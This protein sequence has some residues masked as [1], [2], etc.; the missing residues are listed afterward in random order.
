FQKRSATQVAK[1]KEKEGEEP[2][3]IDP[4]P[5]NIDSLVQFQIQSIDARFCDDLAKFWKDVTKS[6][7]EG[8][9][10]IRGPKDPAS[11][12]GGVKAPEGKAWVVEVSGFTYH[13]GKEKF[14]RDTLVTMLAEKGM[15]APPVKKADGK[16]QDKEKGDEKPAEK[17][18]TK[19]DDK[20]LASDDPK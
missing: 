9:D 12:K 7:E 19:A 3:D 6:K 2:K 1:A 18:E 16:Q 17:A 4:L 5:A 11:K 20:P 13:H 8:D 14:I 15:I 10:D